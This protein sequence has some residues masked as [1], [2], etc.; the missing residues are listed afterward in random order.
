MI[1]TT[2]DLICVILCIT[3]TLLIGVQLALHNF[4]IEEVF[5]GE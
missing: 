5:F 1:K 3:G 2:Y 4:N